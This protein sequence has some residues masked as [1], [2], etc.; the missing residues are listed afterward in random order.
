[1]ARINQHKKSARLAF[2]RDRAQI[3]EN[4]AALRRSLDDN[5]GIDNDITTRESTVSPSKRRPL[6]AS[7]EIALQYH[8]LLTCLERTTVCDFLHFVQRFT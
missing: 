3:D 1:M 2:L 7:E 5:E 6:T 4:L 8:H